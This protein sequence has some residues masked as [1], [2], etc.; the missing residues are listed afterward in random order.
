MR[1]TSRSRSI[2]ICAVFFRFQPLAFRL[3]FPQLFRQL[4]ELFAQFSETLVLGDLPPCLFHFLLRPQAP[5]PRL[6]SFPSRPHVVRTP[7]DRLRLA[8]E[9]N[10][11]MLPIDR[12]SPH[13]TK[14]KHLLDYRLP[15]PLH[16]SDG[17][18]TP[19]PL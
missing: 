7:P 5:T 16:I 17:F 18:H 3:E 4:L 1:R 6:V 8:F 15:T 11:Q 13:A 19:L 14:R 2:A 9:L 10:L 12:S